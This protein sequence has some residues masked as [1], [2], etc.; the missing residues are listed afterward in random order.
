MMVSFFHRLHAFQQV[1]QKSRLIETSKSLLAARQTTN[2]L[3][4]FLAITSTTTTNIVCMMCRI[5][6]IPT[7]QLLWVSTVNTLRI[8]S[9][10]A[11]FVVILKA[12][13]LYIQL[14]GILKYNE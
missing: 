13:N 11:E 6:W 5:H 3:H 2:P 10:K 1:S 7:N 9:R 8:Y 4:E 14:T 12:Y